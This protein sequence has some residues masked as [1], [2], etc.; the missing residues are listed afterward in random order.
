[1]DRLD[2]LV[3]GSLFSILLLFVAMFFI[4][5]LWCFSHNRDSLCMC[6]DQ[7][8]KTMLS[9]NSSEFETVLRK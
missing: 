9:C 8:Q 6:T 3:L 4:T 7:T 5:W 1:M 2:K